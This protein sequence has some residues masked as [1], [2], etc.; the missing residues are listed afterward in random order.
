MSSVV[1]LR[2]PPP[3]F[4]S[5]YPVTL[6]VARTTPAALGFRCSA[7]RVTAG[8][9]FGSGVERSRGRGG[10]RKA[11]DG[12][13]ERNPIPNAL[14]S[15]QGSASTGTCPRSSPD[16]APDRFFANAGRRQGL[17]C[18]QGN[19]VNAL[20]FIRQIAPLAGALSLQL[21]FRVA[22]KVVDACAEELAAAGVRIVSAPA[23]QPFGHRTLF[24][25]HPDGNV[26]E[27]YA[28][29]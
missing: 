18:S 14:A 5:R 27:I 28:E 16:R 10:G 24:F 21:A 12:G 6:P 29:I 17:G 4:T 11:D 8:E 19:Q 25:R 2:P 23:D 3:P 9:G 7:T 15:L 26:L 20:S 22:P 1:G 13:H